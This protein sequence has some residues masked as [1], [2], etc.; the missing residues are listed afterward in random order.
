[1]VYFSDTHCVFRPT[2]LLT[3]EILIEAEDKALEMTSPLSPSRGGVA[4][5]VDSDDVGDL[6]V[7]PD[8]DNESDPETCNKVEE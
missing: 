5:P 1:M 8:V 4:S 3:Y 2:E 6:E 7:D